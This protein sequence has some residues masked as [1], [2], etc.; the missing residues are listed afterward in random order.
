VKHVDPPNS[1]AA[2]RLLDAGPRFAASEPAFLAGVYGDS[3]AL[4]DGVAARVIHGG[5]SGVW[6]LSQSDLRRLLIPAGGWLGYNYLIFNNP[7]TSRSVLI[8]KRGPDG[9]TAQPIS[10]S[11]TGS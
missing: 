10:T 2:K 9:P 4:R 11:G 6:R 8:Q 5:M 3:V 7:S 1:A